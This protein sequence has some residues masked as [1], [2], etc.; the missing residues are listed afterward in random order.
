MG[1]YKVGDRVWVSHLEDAW[2]GGVVV[3]STP[4]VYTPLSRGSEA[5]F[6]QSR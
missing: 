2:L 5:L 4:K 3:A 1:D 6:P